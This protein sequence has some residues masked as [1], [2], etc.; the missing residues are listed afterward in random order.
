[1]LIAGKANDFSWPVT[2][3]VQAVSASAPVGRVNNAKG[4]AETVDIR[5]MTKAESP[6][7]PRTQKA[8]LSCAATQVPEMRAANQYHLKARFPNA[9]QMEAFLEASLIPSLHSEALHS[10]CPLL[11]AKVAQTGKHHRQ[12]SLVG[13]GDYLLVAN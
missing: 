10:G 8:A 6:V 4:R 2:F 9:S 13:S 7:L 3:L 12:P 1:M 11:V 5:E